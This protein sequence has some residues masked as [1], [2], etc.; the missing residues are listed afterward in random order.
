MAF[1]LAAPLGRCESDASTRWS[2]RAFAHGV[3]LARILLKVS[4]N[5]ARPHLRLLCRESYDGAVVSPD[6]YRSAAQ[7]APDY[8]DLIKGLLGCQPVPLPRAGRG[9]AWYAS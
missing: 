7:K 1:I 5:T 2:H 4:G 8:G 6:Q 9:D 3:E